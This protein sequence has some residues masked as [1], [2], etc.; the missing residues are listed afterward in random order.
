DLQAEYEKSRVVIVPIYQGAGT[1]IKVV[2]ALQMNRACVVTE[3]ATR[4][5]SDVFEDGKDYFV[6]KN[7]KDFVEKLEKLLTNETLNIQTARNGKEK[8]LQHFSFNMFENKVK[9][10]LK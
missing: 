2:E 8:T 10:F 5:L 6:A 3:F 9:E 1:N 4:G 7:D